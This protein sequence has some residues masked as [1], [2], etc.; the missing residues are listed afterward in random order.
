MRIA[1]F[2]RLMPVHRGVGGMQGHAQNLYRGLAKRGHDVHVFT[3][4]FPGKTSEI[5]ENVTI[6]YL[7]G[8]KPAEYS[9]EYRR[10]AESKLI[11]LH[12]EKPFNIIHSESSAAQQL[13]K[14][15][16]PIV[17]T[18]HGLNYCSTQ[19]KINQEYASGA[20]LQLNWRDTFISLAKEI[21]DLEKYDHH[22][23]I[24]HQALKDLHEVYRL[25]SE[26]TTLVFNGFDTT[27]FKPDSILRDKIRN[28]LKIP[29]HSFVLGVAG[30]LT[31]DKG[32]R[33]LIQALPSFLIKYPRLKLIIIGNSGIENEYKTLRHPNILFLGAKKYEEMPA[34]YNAMDIFLNPTYRYLGLD[35]TMQEALL[36]GTPVIATDTGS[37]KESLVINEKFGCT[38]ELANR[39][40]LYKCIET[41]MS[42]QD[43]NRNSISTHVRAFS[44]QEA[45]CSKMEEVFVKLSRD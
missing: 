9:S 12:K 26:K 34:Y 28:E 11:E 7:E 15:I 27:Q 31:V 44:S 40:Q 35:M 25:P 4:S 30:R 17:A 23:A 14:G 38:H 20:K 10:L 21:K 22:I 8:C 16:L 19:S 45:M 36:C 37:I 3:T 1:G 42:R 43:F 18:W 33:F 5:E 29:L 39:E 24:S 32:H 13:C 2:I 6:H 41:C